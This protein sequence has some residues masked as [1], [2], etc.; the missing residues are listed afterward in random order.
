MQLETAH[1]IIGGAGAKAREGCPPQTDTKSAQAKHRPFGA[2][3]KASC[4]K[5]PEGLRNRRRTEKPALITLAGGTSLG[6]VFQEGSLLTLSPQLE[7]C[8]GDSYNL[9]RRSS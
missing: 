2:T 6:T 4:M 8:L 3:R 5:S 9:Q 1:F 7:R